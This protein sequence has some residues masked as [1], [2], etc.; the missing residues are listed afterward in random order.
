MSVA[1]RRWLIFGLSV[2]TVALVVAAVLQPGKQPRAYDPNT[3]HRYDQTIALSGTGGVVLDAGFF[4]GDTRVGRVVTVPAVEIVDLETGERERQI[5]WPNAH[6]HAHLGEVVA[7]QISPDGTRVV[8]ASRDHKVRIWRI[9]SGELLTRFSS[10]G[11][12]AVAFS[13][14]GRHILTGHN[15][16]EVWAWRNNGVALKPFRGLEESVTSLTFSPDGKRV[17]A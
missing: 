2:V 5:L 12:V 7:A 10:S 17:L 8:T 1:G 6:G 16:G 14:D 11:T 4:A 15:D 9:E 13:P 3:A